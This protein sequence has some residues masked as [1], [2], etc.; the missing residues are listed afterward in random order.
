VAAGWSGTTV[1]ATVGS[2]PRALPSVAGAAAATWPR[3]AIVP[4]VVRPPG[5][6]MPTLAPTRA[7]PW[8]EAPQRDRDHAG[9]R[10][11]D[12]GLVARSGEAADGGLVETD[13]DRARQ[14]HH[15]AELD[16]AGRGEPEDAL[17]APDRGAGGPVEVAV[18]RA[19]QGAGKAEGHKV[20]LQ[21]RHVR[22]VVHAG[23]EGS[24]GR[25]RWPAI[26]RTRP[27]S[28]STC[29][30]RSARCGV[31]RWASC[32]ASR[33]SRSGWWRWPWPSVRSRRPGRWTWPLRSRR[34]STG[35]GPRPAR[36]SSG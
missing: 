33:R 15:P 29:R 14:E 35:T 7:S 5:R 36:D 8:R 23:G 22:P 27:A 25:S 6:S 30:T 9:R 31:R 11:R 32:C 34:R 26:P 20:R 19:E 4:G 17:P 12:V 16:R 28:S 21:L 18:G 3:W 2:A 24:P 1:S 10:R 13:P